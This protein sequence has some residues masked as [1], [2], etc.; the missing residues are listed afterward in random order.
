[1]PTGHQILALNELDIGNIKKYANDPVTIAASP[2]LCAVILS[3]SSTF[4]H[5]LCSFNQYCF[6]K[7]CHV[8]T[9]YYPVIMFRDM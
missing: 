6:P 7:C 5:I 4:N 2:A 1:M 8:F 9:R 3:S